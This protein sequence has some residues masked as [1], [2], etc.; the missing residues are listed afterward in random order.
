MKYLVQT[1][2]FSGSSSWQSATGPFLVMPPRREQRKRCFNWNMLIGLATVVGI[3]A[4]G[5][6]GVALLISR[7]LK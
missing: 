5:W 2:S 3:S 4:A 6:T 7:W 1:E